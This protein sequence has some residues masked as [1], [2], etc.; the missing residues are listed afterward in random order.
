MDSFELNKIMGAVLGSLVFIFALG[1]ISE[2]I[3]H[4]IENQGA[5]YELPEPEAGVS[6]VAAV[7]EDIPIAVLLASANAEIGTRNFRSCAGCHNA[8]PGAG[9]K[10]GPNLYGI[11]NRVI[12]S[13]DGY[14]YS[15]GFLDLKDEG[16]IWDFDRLNDFIKNPKRSIRGTK[17]AAVT[18]NDKRRADILAY[19][20]TLSDTPVA[21]PTV[22]QTAPE[23]DET[24]TGDAAAATTQDSVQEDTTTQS[25][26]AMPDGANTFE[27]DA[28]EAVNEGA[29]A[30]EE[31]VSPGE[32][33]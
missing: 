12:G 5:A 26:D 24:M 27:D 1:F 25:G 22:T 33:N 20:A 31:N 4:P 10:I 23:Q 19:L 9:K 21:L 17:M 32:T 6:A 15:Q 11:V 16:A 30:V 7:Q 3:Y 28:F 14:D 13:Q 2:A 18:P 29:D 8:E